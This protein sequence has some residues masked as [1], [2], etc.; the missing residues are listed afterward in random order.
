MR[1]P[2]TTRVV[3]ALMFVLTAVSAATALAQRPNILFIMSDDHAYQ[4]ISAYGSNRNETPN[5]DRLAEDG[6]L[7]TNGDNDT[8]PLWYL[9]EVEGVRT[10]VRVANLSLLNT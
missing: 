8:Y 10:D 3:A 5:I 9:Q 4:A 2:R 6:I 7:F 1:L